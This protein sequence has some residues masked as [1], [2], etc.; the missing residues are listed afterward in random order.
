M[1]KP[2]H[3]REGACKR[4]LLFSRSHAE[5]LSG[6]AGDSPGSLCGASPEATPAS[7][8]PRELIC[9]AAGV[10]KHLLRSPTHDGGLRLARTSEGAA[11]AARTT[12]GSTVLLDS[13]SRPD[14]AAS[15]DLQHSGHRLVAACSSN[16]RS[17]EQL[18]S[19]ACMR[20]AEAM[21]MCSPPAA[22][23][24]RLPPAPRKRSIETGE[25]KLRSRCNVPSRV[26]RVLVGMAPAHPSELQDVRAWL[27][28]LESR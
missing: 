3:S 6:A 7:P 18:C 14:A 23:V 11:H 9:H 16:K 19:P 10:G 17:L 13:T 21:P 27:T 22:A 2:D 1:M 5:E 12:A 8:C 4:R 28:L 25:T 20:Q 15:G 24:A 26:A